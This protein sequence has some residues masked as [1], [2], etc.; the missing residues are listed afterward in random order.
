MLQIIFL[1]NIVLYFSLYW[2]RV[3]P[4]LTNLVF[5]QSSSIYSIYL[6]GCSALIILVRII[7]SVV[8]QFHSSTKVVHVDISL[9]VSVPLSLSPYR[10]SSINTFRPKCYHLFVFILY[11]KLT[12]WVSLLR[13]LHYDFIIVSLTVFL[14]KLIFLMDCVDNFCQSL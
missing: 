10:C 9:C 5:F 4:P 12:L 2:F 8:Y 7:F 1:S 14:C 3:I 13:M 11:T 6:Y